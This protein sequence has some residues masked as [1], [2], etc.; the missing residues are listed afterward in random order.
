MGLH[1]SVQIN[2][3]QCLNGFLTRDTYVSS[4]D[5]PCPKCN[6]EAFLLKAKRVAE[7]KRPTSLSCPCCDQAGSPAD[8][9]LSAL[10]TAQ[11]YNTQTLGAILSDL[12]TVT[13]IDHNR[14]PIQFQ[15]GRGAPTLT[16]APRRFS[17]DPV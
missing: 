11:Q 2:I 12:G 1:C 10:R 13:T 8:Y 7:S 17:C 3:W 9:W 16:V 4:T 15:Y 5:Y 14:A 6:T